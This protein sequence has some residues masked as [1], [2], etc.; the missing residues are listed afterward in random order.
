METLLKNSCRIS[1]A[2]IS[3]FGVV[4][5]GAE[6][7]ELSFIDSDGERQLCWVISY[8]IDRPSGLVKT[9]NNPLKINERNLA[10]H[11]QPQADVVSM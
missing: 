9:R 3:F 5:P 2:K 10:L 7:H 8:D 6:R 11:G 4:G 1:P